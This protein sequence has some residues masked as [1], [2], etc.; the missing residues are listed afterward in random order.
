VAERQ[1][2][3]D[4]YAKEGS[5]GEPQAIG[6]R[7]DGMVHIQEDLGYRADVHDGFEKAQNRR[8][9]APALDDGYGAD[10]VQ[11]H[12]RDC[13]RTMSQ[14]V[15]KT[16]VFIGDLTQLGSRASQPQPKHPASSV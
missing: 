9:R 7:I 8:E 6:Q 13:G 4:G 12:V 15:M 14:K 5:A 11:R 2:L 1:A 16:V 10:G 3:L